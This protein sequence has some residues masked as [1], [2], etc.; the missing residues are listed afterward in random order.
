MPTEEMVEVTLKLKMPKATARFFLQSALERAINTSLEIVGEQVNNHED[1]YV[2]HEDLTEWKPIL[3]TLWCAIHD[4][5]YRALT[6]REDDGRVFEL[7]KGD[8]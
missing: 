1:A 4:K 3:C 5:V 6:K 2:N 7:R 8:L